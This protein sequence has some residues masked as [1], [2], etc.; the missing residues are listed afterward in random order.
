MAVPRGSRISVLLCRRHHRLVHEGGWTVVRGPDGDV[1]V[2]RPDGAPLPQAPDA[3]GCV[4]DASLFAPAIGHMAAAGMPTGACEYP[5][6]CDSTRFDIGWAIDVLR[7]P[8]EAAAA[9]L[10][11]GRAGSLNYC[12]HD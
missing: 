12:H 9:S 1:T 6:I 3:P 5:P 8:L 7:T 4:S 2:R 10:G 11:N